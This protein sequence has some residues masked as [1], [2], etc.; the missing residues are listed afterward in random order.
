M[1]SRSSLFHLSLHRHK[2]IMGVEKSS[3]GGLVFGAVFS[4]VAQAFW[5]YP[6]LIILFVLARWVTKKDDQFVGV[7]LKYLNEEHVYDALPRP[8]DFQKRP[9]GWGKGLPR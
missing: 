6:L 1:A 3:F 2:L 5:A 9:K 7:L 4:L 8:S